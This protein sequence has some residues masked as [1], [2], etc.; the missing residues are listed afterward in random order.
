MAKVKK[1]DVE[2]R[3]DRTG[4]CAY[5]IV[6]RSDSQASIDWCKLLLDDML[7]REENESWVLGVWGW[8]NNARTFSGL[9]VDAERLLT[10]WMAEIQKFAAPRLVQS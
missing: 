2:V 5:D 3:I 7:L 4:A 1:V 8:H 6:L 9:R 10:R